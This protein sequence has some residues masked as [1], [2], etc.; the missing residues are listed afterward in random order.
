M[1]TELAHRYEDGVDV[2][3]LWDGA[4]GRVSVAVAVDGTGEAFELDVPRSER[5]LEVFRHPFTFAALRTI[6]AG[7]VYRLPGT[8]RAVAT[9]AACFALL[10]GGTALATAATA[11]RDGAV[12]PT[13]R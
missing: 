5:P 2:R 1:A 9:I 4:A 8:R 7:R 13:A 12:Y 6:D 3:L 11:G 10:A